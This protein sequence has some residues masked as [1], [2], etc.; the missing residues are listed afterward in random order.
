[1]PQTAPEIISRRVTIEFDAAHAS[2]WQR[3]RSIEELLNGISFVFPSGERFFIQSVLHYQDRIDDPVLQDQVRRFVHQEAMHTKEH[4][5]CNVVLIEAFP[6]GRAIEK[7]ATTAFSRARR[8][9]LKASQLACT[10]ALE[11]LTAVLADGLL[12]NQD[13]FLAESEPD[14]A[15]L[16][17]WHAVEETEHKAVA[18][19]VY[20]DVIGKGLFSYLHRIV[21]MF[22]T[23]LVFF[24]TLQFSLRQMKREQPDATPHK[25]HFRKLMKEIISFDLYF[26]YYKFSFHPWNYDN[27]HLID[28]WKRRYQDFGM[29]AAADLGG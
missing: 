22:L 15:A 5:R 2:G 21:V 28:E 3:Y 7:Y 26:D 6:F 16:W 4:A 17:L 8:L 19:D 29:D 27:S 12:R 10:C 24:F 1:M 9:L 14:F 25:T 23:T 13:A 11:H 20:R 18:F